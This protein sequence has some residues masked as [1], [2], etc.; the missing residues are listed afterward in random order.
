LSTEP[1]WCEREGVDVAQIQRETS[2]DESAR[3]ADPEADRLA[4]DA[5]QQLAR[6]YSIDTVQFWDC[7]S[8]ENVVIPS[9][10]FSD[11]SLPLAKEK[12]R[13]G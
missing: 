13:C 3:A 1:R 9:F 10:T 4:A 5:L 11:R 2:L 8:I 7:T 6:A 12:A